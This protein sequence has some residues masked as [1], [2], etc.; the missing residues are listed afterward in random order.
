MIS[1]HA[2]ERM[3]QRAI[4]PLVLD[5][6]YRYGREEF[7]NGATVLFF[8]QH[9]RRKALRALKDTLQRFDKVSDTYVITSADD[10]RAITVGHR[11]KRIRQK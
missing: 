3:Q 9:S 4:P 7:Q 10:G 8:D 5:L 6:L 11:T 1:K 2:L